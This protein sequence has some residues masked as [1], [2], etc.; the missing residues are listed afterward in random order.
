MRDLL[1]AGLV[2]VPSV[3]TPNMNYDIAPES[4]WRRSIFRVLAPFF[5]VVAVAVAGGVGWIWYTNKS[6]ELIVNGKIADGRTVV[7]NGSSK[8]LIEGRKAAESALALSDSE[9]F[10]A[11]A[12]IAR[13][14]S[15]LGLLYGDFEPTEIAELNSR[16]RGTGFEEDW[17]IADLA[18]SLYERK[19]KG[20]VVDLADAQSKA[21][22]WLTNHKDAF[23]VH[24]LL[25]EMYASQG[26]TGNARK[27]Y[28][29]SVGADSGSALGEISLGRLALLDG[30][31]ERADGYFD[32]ALARSENHPL[33][34][35][36]RVFS[37]LDRST[38]LRAAVEILNVDLN[39]QEGRE[40]AA[41]RAL[42][43]AR[44]NFLQ[45]AFA[46]VPEF[47][48]AAEGADDMQ[49]RAR[50]ALLYV[51]IGL[52]KDATRVRASIGNGHN[53]APM[54]KV[55]DGRL[56]WWRGFSEKCIAKLG[57]NGSTHG[58]LTR[59]LCLFDIYKFKEARK[60][61]RRAYALAPD[62]L[63]IALWYE[64]ANLVT[65]T[66]KSAKEKAE[67]ALSTLGLRAAI[68]SARLP[69]GLALLLTGD[70]GGA[71]RKLQYTLDD[72][73]KDTPNAEMHRSQVALGRA[74]LREG[75]YKDAR[76]L[77][78]DALRAVPGFADADVLLCELDAREGKANA[79][80]RLSACSEK[81]LVI[82]TRTWR[83]LSSTESETE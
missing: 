55:L 10:E 52:Y 75:K 46:K 9:L 40:I 57:K 73:S 38:G 41:H 3:R 69:H 47:L 12:I 14:T 32:S 49:V 6:A 11:N 78:D 65:A 61:L 21:T 64:A 22:D 80:G 63:A 82:R 42:G 20:D 76:K 23:L 60:V 30:E 26:D 36:G 33:A 5:L 70:K 56:L 81:Q 79:E 43:F 29:E 53:N 25:G 19:R 48:V 66:G 62:S 45:E 37:K 8:M 34:L 27:Q 74:Y 24:W 28:L 59:G 50:V 44:A 68:K 71:R 54:V 16:N 67:S 18:L 15:L 4:R 39:D 31:Y 51:E 13:N 58:L 1:A 17:L 35:L 77:A 83:S 7:V 72:V 2:D